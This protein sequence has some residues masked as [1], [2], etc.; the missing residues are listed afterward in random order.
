MEDYNAL[1]SVTITAPLRGPALRGAP[2][3]PDPDLMEER[4]THRHV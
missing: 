2:Q 4:R 1:Y 3:T